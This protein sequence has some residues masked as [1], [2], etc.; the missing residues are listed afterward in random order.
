MQQGKV[1]LLALAMALILMLGW[2]L[3]LHGQSPATEKSKEASPNRLDFEIISSFDGKYLGDTPGHMG[4]VGALGNRRPHLALGDKIY[5]G[6]EPIG[7]ITSLEWN[8]TNSSLDVEFD[9]L[10]NTRISVGDPVWVA[11]ESPQQRNQR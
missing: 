3:G 11:I 1:L 10:P 8:R 4:R 2:Q 7:L 5:R 6:E 9:P